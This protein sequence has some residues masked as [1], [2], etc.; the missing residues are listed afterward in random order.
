[1]KTYTYDGTPFQAH[2]ANCADGFKTDRR[3]GLIYMCYRIIDADGSSEIMNVEAASI[4]GDFCALC[5]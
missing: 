4:A 3:Y 1:M 5:G 2:N